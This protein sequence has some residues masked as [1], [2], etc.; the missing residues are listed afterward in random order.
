MLRRRFGPDGE[1]GVSAIEF[2]MLMPVFLP[3]IFLL[4]QAGLYFH[5]ANVTQA[6]AQTTGRVLRTYPGNPGQ[7][8][9]TALPSE[10][11]LQGQ[12]SRIAVE[13]WE[14]LDANKTSSQPTAEVALNTDGF[15]QLTVTVHSTCVNLLPGILPTL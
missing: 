4:V 15:N 8:P 7:D 14:S 5:A 1:R 9:T 12:A 2:A 10:G 6:V 3:L 11:F 13:T